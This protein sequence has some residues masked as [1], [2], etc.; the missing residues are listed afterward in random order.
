MD[1]QLTASKPAKCPRT[2]RVKIGS[3]IRTVSRLVVKWVRVTPVATRQL[4]ATRKST[5]EVAN[6]TDSVDVFGTLGQE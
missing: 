4:G 2:M 3:V 1:Y 6:S 5:L